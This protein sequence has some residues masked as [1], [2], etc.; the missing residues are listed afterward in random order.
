MTQTTQ[1]KLNRLGLYAAWFVTTALLVTAAVDRHPYSF[2]TLLRWICCPIFA[3]S[4]VWAHGKNRV[5]G[6][7][8]FGVLAGV[9]NPIFRVHLDR[10][11]WIGVN[12]FTVGAIIIAAAAFWRPPSKSPPTSN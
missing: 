10:S 4:A 2:Y 12:W 3:Y 1:E 6:V 11:T 5:L 7:W 9:Y 8:V